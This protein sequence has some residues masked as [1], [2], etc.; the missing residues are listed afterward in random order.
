MAPS[1]W[2]RLRILAYQVCPSQTVMLIA[3]SHREVDK[4]VADA[5]DDGTKQVDVQEHLGQEKYSKPVKVFDFRT[6][7]M[8]ANATG[9]RPS[10]FLLEGAKYHAQEP[11]YRVMVIM[12]TPHSN[13]C[14]RMEDGK[15]FLSM[16]VWES[17]GYDHT[18]EGG[19][20]MDTNPRGLEKCVSKGTVAEVFAHLNMYFGTMRSLADLFH[21][22]GIDHY[23]VFVC[24][25]HIHGTRALPYDGQFCAL[26]YYSRYVSPATVDG[27]DYDHTLIL[28]QVCPTQCWRAKNFKTMPTYTGW[29]QYNIGSA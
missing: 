2:Q 9:Q 15:P 27:T 26:D 8:Y 21:V 13:R 22:A 14:A 6:N 10:S 25:Y 5:G 3:M 11:P 4:A 23:T 20:G 1:G 16:E 29:Q 12:S 7:G 19:K 18:K 28:D 17:W 24:G